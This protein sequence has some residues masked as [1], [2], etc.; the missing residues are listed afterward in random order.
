VLPRKFFTPTLSC[1]LLALCF[2][3]GACAKKQKGVI[4]E[5]QVNAF[6]K[7]VDRAANSKDIEAVIALLSEDVHLDLTIEGFG[8][9]QTMSLDREQYRKQMEQTLRMTN[10]YDYKRGETIIKV[11]PD[12]Q[13]AFVIADIYETTKI[14]G[15]TI[16]TVSRE[17][18]TLEMEDGKLVVTRSAAV[19]RPLPSMNKSRPTV[20]AEF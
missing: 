4:T 3:S 14:G 16:G 13:T 17:T 12:G 19:S 2:L 10:V 1:V 18:S 20:P 8:P 11:E 7:E 9:T 6:L 15:Q 5:Q